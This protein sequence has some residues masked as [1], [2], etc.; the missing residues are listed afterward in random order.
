MERAVFQAQSLEDA[1]KNIIRQLA[2]RA[3]A[4][5]LMMLFGGGLPQ[6]MNFVQAMFGGFRASGGGVTAGRPYM[7]GERG[8]EMFVP[9]SSGTI[10]P[11]HQMGSPD[12]GAIVNAINKMTLRTEVVGRIQGEDIFITNARGQSSFSR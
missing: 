10:V 5:G 2:S 6:G 11:N 8:A 7:V 1:L 9:S 12:V 4:T 3:L